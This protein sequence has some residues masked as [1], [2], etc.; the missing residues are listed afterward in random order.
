MIPNRSAPLAVPASVD[1][2]GRC[3]ASWAARW[4]RGKQAGAQ[5]DGKR[6]A[7]AAAGLAAFAH[8][9]G[10]GTTCLY[11]YVELR[12]VKPELFKDIVLM[13]APAGFMTEIT[14]VWS[15]EDLTR[16]IGPTLHC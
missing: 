13:S 5:T 2:Y 10:G 6:D 9:A 12:K 3:N 14:Q 7:S 15:I 1:R 11:S 8:E 4:M 16:R